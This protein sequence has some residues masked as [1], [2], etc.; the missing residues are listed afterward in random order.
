MAD[1]IN[2]TIYSL[3]LYIPNFIPSFETQLMFNE[4]TQSK[5][6]IYFDEWYTGRRFITDL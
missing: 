5:Y 4:A 3:Y 6:K 1:V 2:V